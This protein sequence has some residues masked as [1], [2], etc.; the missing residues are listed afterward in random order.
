MGE[1]GK[2]NLFSYRFTPYASRL[3]KEWRKDVKS[4]IDEEEIW[5]DF[6]SLLTPHALRLTEI[7]WI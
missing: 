1:A 7:S 3:T 6:S 4:E 5:R 2:I